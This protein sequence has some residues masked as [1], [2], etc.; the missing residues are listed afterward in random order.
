MSHILHRAAKA[1]MPVA[2]GG[3]GVELFDADGRT[4]IDARLTSVMVAIRR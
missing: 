2:V 3:R 4:Y 1:N